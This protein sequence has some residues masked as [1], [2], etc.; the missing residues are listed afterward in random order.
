MYWATK[1]IEGH[2]VVSTYNNSE[3]LTEAYDN[4]KIAKVV[5]PFEAKDI[6]EASIRVGNKLEGGRFILMEQYK[7]GLEIPKRY[8]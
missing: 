4:P 7:N 5:L 2:I 8:Y 1:D 6:K 3:Q